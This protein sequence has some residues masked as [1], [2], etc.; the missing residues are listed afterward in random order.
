MNPPEPMG[1][2]L[3]ASRQDL[4]LFALPLAFF[5]TFVLGRWI[6][7]STVLAI[8]AAGIVCLVLLVDGLFVNP[9]VPEERK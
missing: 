6:V 5:G 3:S 1:S 7:D 2:T 4:I 8:G 9:P